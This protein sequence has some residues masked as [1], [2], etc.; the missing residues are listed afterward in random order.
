MFIGRELPTGDSGA[1]LALISP[2]I[3]LIKYAAGYS[4]TDRQE[5]AKTCAEELANLIIA[6]RCA[7][8][9]RMQ[10]DLS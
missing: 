3:Q 5:A 9:F 7:F 8:P 1:N 10:D 4:M 6:V 2:K